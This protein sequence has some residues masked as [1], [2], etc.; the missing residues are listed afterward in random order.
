[1]LWTHLTFPVSSHFPNRVWPISSRDWIWKPNCVQCVSWVSRVSGGRDSGMVWPACTVGYCIDSFAGLLE[2]W[3]FL[4]SI[5]VAVFLW[6][7]MSGSVW[8]WSNCSLCSKS[9][10]S[11]LICLQMFWH[12]EDK[13][14]SWLLLWL[15][16]EIWVFEFPDIIQLSV[17]MVYLNV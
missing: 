16:Q 14:V 5:P 8:E 13:T 6:L 4:L 17:I 10:T 9:F 11:D 2:I 3:I 7:L 15:N 1:M 12:S